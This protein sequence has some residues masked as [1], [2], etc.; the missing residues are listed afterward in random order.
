LQLNDL[1]QTGDAAKVWADAGKH[2]KNAYI[3][4]LEYTSALEYAVRLVPF[5]CKLIVPIRRQS[6]Y[7]EARKAF[8]KAAKSQLDW[9]EMLWEAWFAFE[10]SHGSVGEI[11]DAF[12]VVERARTQVQA[13]RAKVLIFS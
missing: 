10:H 1:G 7:E 6:D 11:Q 9:P 2:H 8:A 12:D 5:L 13:R 4:W 3:P